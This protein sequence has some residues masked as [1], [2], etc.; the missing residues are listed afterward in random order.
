[1][2]YT[3]PQIWLQGSAPGGFVAARPVVNIHILIGPG[4]VASTEG[5][6]R[7][8]DNC[9]GP[10]SVLSYGCPLLCWVHISVKARDGD[11]MGHAGAQL[12]WLAAGEHYD[13]S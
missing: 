8:T 1:M 9:R 12:E 10:V 4:Q 5:N 13:A 6:Y 11:G 2:V 3:H 7:L